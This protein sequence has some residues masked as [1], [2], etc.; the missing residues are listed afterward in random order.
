MLIT[1]ELCSECWR[2]ICIL[3]YHSPHVDQ[4]LSE[5]NGVRISADGDGSVSVA[6]FTFFAIW[7]ANHGTGNL[8]NLS[9]LGS[10]FPNYATDQIIW[11]SHFML[12]R[13]GL[14]SILSR[15][16]LWAGKGGE[17][18]RMREN[19]VRYQDEKKGKSYQKKISSRWHIEC[20]PFQLIIGIHTVRDTCLVQSTSIR[21]DGASK[22]QGCKS[23]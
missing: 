12:L 3:Q 9:D 23:S 10:T 18:W 6:T 15:A 20:D 14:R 19:R 5:S 7:N 13:V 2:N 1:T 4:I 22:A 17:S 8:T 21:R 16:Q 11:H